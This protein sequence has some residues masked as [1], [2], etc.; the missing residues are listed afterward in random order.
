MF[1]WNILVLKLLISLWSGVVSL[2]NCYP[3]YEVMCSLQ[4]PWFHVEVICPLLETISLPLKCHFLP[5]K[6]LPPFGIVWSHIEIINLTL[7]WH[8]LIFTNNFDIA[9][10]DYKPNSP[11]L[12]S[13]PSLSPILLARD[14]EGENWWVNCKILRQMFFKVLAVNFNVLGL[15]FLMVTFLFHLWNCWN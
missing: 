9:D 4:N 2:W 12:W 10:S 14:K 7:K 5:Q 6:L 13:I 8:I 1:G 11:S 3:F 15:N